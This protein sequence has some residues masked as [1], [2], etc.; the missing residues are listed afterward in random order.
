M[1]SQRGKGSDFGPNG[2]VRLLRHSDLRTALALTRAAGWNQ[3][4]NDWERLLTLEPEGC[5][6]LECDGEIRSTT[7][8][9]CYGRELAWIGMVLT[10]PEYR[11]RGFAQS[12]MERALRFI[13][14]RRVATVKL[15]ATDRGVRI[16]RKFGFTD[17]CAIERWERLPPPVGVP[18]S[19]SYCPDDAYDRARFGAD[20]SALLRSLATEDAASLVGQGYAMGRPGF[21]AAYFGPCVAR[22][23]D[24]ARRLLRWFLA[25]HSK[26][27][28]F[29]DLFSGNKAAVE[30]ARDFGFAPVRR[31][32]RMALTREADVRAIRNHDEVFAIAGFE[33]G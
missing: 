3:T 18:E 14:E 20:R 1:A 7:T 15:D 13:D 17:E 11:R 9:L 25:R 6:A 4:A 21:N 32:T 5:F 24:A 23:S 28:V 8:A 19:L 30:L 29:W 31:L 27:R 16:Y 22:S 2:S 33:L 10:H 26:E 12:L